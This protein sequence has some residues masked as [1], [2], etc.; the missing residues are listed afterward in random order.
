MCTKRQTGRINENVED[1]WKNKLITKV[2]QTAS[3]LAAERE[4]M[5]Q[6]SDYGNQQLDY[7]QQH[8]TLILTVCCHSS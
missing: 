2:G 7:S 3:Y 8:S 6:L 4:K 1:G 5:A